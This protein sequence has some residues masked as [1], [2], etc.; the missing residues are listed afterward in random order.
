M[1]ALVYIG[2]GLWISVGAVIFVWVMIL[3]AQTM[4]NRV[5]K[6]GETSPLQLTSTDPADYTELGREYL[7]KLIRARLVMLAYLPTLFIALY[8]AMS[9]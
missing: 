9:L 1:R 7:R 8:I 3:Y 6:A 5:P 4:N 2:A